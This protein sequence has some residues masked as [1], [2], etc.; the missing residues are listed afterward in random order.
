MVARY[1]GD[2]FGILLAG[3]DETAIT[4]ITQRILER[5]REHPLDL[6]ESGC[7]TLSVSLGGATYPTDHREMVGLL[8]LADDALY[9]AKSK[10][11]N[12][13][14]TASEITIHHSKELE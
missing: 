2:E 10:G 5:L 3:A 1:G 9:A 7:L 11:G 13:V 8:A 4:V 6:G 14:Q 12:Q